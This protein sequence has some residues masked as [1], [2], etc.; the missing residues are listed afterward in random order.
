MSLLEMEGIAIISSPESRMRGRGHRG[1]RGGEY[2]HPHEEGPV[3]GRGAHRGKQEIR[4]PEEKRQALPTCHLNLQIPGD[5]PDV[6]VPRPG[7]NAIPASSAL[8]SLGER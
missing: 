7:G 2:H 1:V 4:L 5:A 3:R 6:P 8:S